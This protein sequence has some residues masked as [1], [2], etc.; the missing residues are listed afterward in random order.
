MCRLDWK[1]TTTRS[2]PSMKKKCQRYFETLS[3]TC[4]DELLPSLRIPTSLFL[5]QVKI[6]YG[7]WAGK[8]AIFSASRILL[9]RRRRSNSKYLN[10]RLLHSE[11]SRSGKAIR[12]NAVNIPA[13]FDT[14]S[15][16]HQQN[17]THFSKKKKIPL[18]CLGLRE[19]FLAYL[20]PQPPTRR[21]SGGGCS[22]KIPLLLLLRRHRRCLCVCHP[23]DCAD[24]IG[25]DS[26]RFRWRQ[27]CLLTQFRRFF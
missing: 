21:G 5:C 20:S 26:L 3:N 16:Y 25:E 14:Y 15:Q 27:H 1:I 9:R 7:V 2:I 6:N 11:K 8:P 13:T 12:Q 19:R 18:S 24:K 22:A 4:F 10:C 23:P 17:Y